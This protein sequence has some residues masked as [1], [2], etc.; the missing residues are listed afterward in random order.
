VQVG[1]LDDPHDAPSIPG[2]LESGCAIGVL[3]NL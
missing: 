3:L 1:H 2:R